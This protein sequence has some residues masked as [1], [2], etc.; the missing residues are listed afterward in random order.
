MIEDDPL[1][2]AWVTNLSNIDW[3]NLPDFKIKLYYADQGVE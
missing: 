3:D 1:G 2:V